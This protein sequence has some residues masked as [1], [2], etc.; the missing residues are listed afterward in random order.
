MLASCVEIHADASG[1]HHRGLV[2]TKARRRQR[3]PPRSTRLEVDRHEPEPI[4]DAVAQLDQALAL[5]GLR[6]WL[7]DFEHPH[8]R[9][10]VWPTLGER[11]HSGAQDH[12]LADAELGLLGHQVL[13]EPSTG[14][15]PGPEGT[16]EIGVHV[17][18]LAPPRIRRG[19]LQADLVFEHVRRR[20]ELDVHRSP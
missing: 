13:D 11:V 6:G 20:I 16:R 17:R 5:P 8:P 18:P 2:G 14:R 4:G 9:G 15:D 10:D 7:V 19:E 12:V 1:D 3:W